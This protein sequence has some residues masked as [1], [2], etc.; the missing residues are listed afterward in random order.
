M[1]HPIAGIW[2]VDIDIGG[3]HTYV[4]HAFHADG[5]LHIK[6]GYG[7]SHVLWEATGERSFR[8]HGQI[9]IEP[10]AFHFIGWQ[11]LDGAGEVSE[12]G[13][14]YTASGEI[15]MPQPDGTSARSRATLVG[16]RV[17]FGSG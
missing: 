1:T 11:Y 8:L 7:A 12:D 4:T 14:S 5:I 17:A 3:R 10:E 2:A 16:T 9:P 6:A 15:D 13:E